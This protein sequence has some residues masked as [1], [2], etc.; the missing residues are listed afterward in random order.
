MDSEGS[1]PEWRRRVFGDPYLVWH[2]GPGF[3]HL[4]DLAGMAPADVARMLAAGLDAGDPL[5]AQSI[6][7]LATEAKAPAGSVAPLRAAIPDAAETF[8][9]RVAQALHVLTGDESWADPIVSVLTSDAW[10]GTRLDAAIALTGFAPTP[11]LIR[12]LGQAVRDPEYLV[13]YHAANTLLRYAGHDTAIA[14]LPGLFTKIRHPIDGEATQADT[15]NW[16]QAADQLT[17]DALRHHN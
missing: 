11:Q 9:V 2:D 5:A 8:L 3:D 15:A 14:D 7:A 12:P 6:T 4:L 16:R 17:A 13:R 1:W 10:R